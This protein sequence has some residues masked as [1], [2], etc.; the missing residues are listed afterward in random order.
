MAV[1]TPMPFVKIQFFTDA[2]LIASGYQLFTYESGGV[3]K[4]N[5]YSDA[6]LT[7]PNTNPIV[8]DSAGR[9]SI[10]LSPTTYK[11]V[12]APP[13]DTDPPTSPTWTMDGVQAAPSLNASLDVTGTAGQALTAGV[14][15]YCS[16]GDGGLTAGRWYKTDADLTYA[17]T[18]AGA[19]GFVVADIAS[20]ASGLIRLNGRVTGFAGLTTGSIYYLSQ[21][22]GGITATPSIAANIRA[23]GFADSTTSIV[24][25]PWVQTRVATSGTEGIVSILAQSFGGAKTFDEQPVFKPHGAVAPAYVS[26]VLDSQ[27]TV[28]GVGNVGVAETTLYTYSLPAG[29]LAAHA[30]A[31]LEPSLRVTFRVYFKN[32]ADV[33]TLKFYFG[34]AVITIATGAINL[35]SNVGVFTVLVRWIDAATQMIYG[36]GIVSTSAL[37]GGLPFAATAAGAEDTSGAGAPIVVKI[38]GQSNA[39]ANDILAYDWLV[40]LVG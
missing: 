39:E 18:L 12:L 32:D 25:S 6:A 15:V 19:I 35:A 4:L 22:A 38:T 23:I 8:L 5:T 2:G 30:T 1:G 14:A 40:E 27:S 33:K 24:F 21:T 16:A 7:T 17:S 9:A 29:T 31:T 26:G 11:F 3:V 10:F 36:S 20:G 28:A 34:A 13:T 37:T